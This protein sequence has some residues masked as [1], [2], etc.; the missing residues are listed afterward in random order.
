MSSDQTNVLQYWMK[1]VISSPGT[2]QHKLAKAQQLYKMNEQDVVAT[3]GKASSYARLNIYASGYVLR[4]LECLAA[5]FPVLHK[6]VGDEVFNAFA[7]ASLVWSPPTSYTLYDLGKNFIAFLVATR[8]TSATNG[9]NNAMLDLPIALAQLERLRQEVMR[10]IGTEDSITMIADMQVEDLFFQPQNITLCLPQSSKLL[11][12][13]FPLKQFFE[14]VANDE[15]YD[16]PEPATTYMAVSRKNYRITIHELSEWQY[17]FL[18]SCNEPINLLAA[19]DNTA[20]SNNLSASELMADLYLWLPVF[21]DSGLLV[22]NE[23]F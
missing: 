13:K 21:C 8:P 2:L 3:S 11:V 12:S 7:K 22:R 5:D 9:A 20:G 6:F 19:I 23:S 1:E 16:L 10:A 17:L 15:T 18:A 4:L 14:K